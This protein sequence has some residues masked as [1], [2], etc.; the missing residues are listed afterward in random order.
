MQARERILIALDTSDAGQAV[1][2]VRLLAGHV[3][4]FKVGLELVHAAGFGIFERLREAGAERIFY[5]AK[6][7]DI[8]NTVA[9]A[10][11]AI[12]RMGVWMV[13]L[14]ASGGL[15]MMTAAAESARSVPNPPLL[16]AVTVLT[17]LSEGKL[18]E[19]LGV[20]R[21]LREQVLHLASLAREAN[22]DGVVAS[23]QE[24]ALL[25]EHIARD[26]LIVTPGIRLADEEVHDQKRVTT[27]AEAVRA[28]AD[29][30]VIGRSV[31]ADPDPLEK[32]ER[33]VRELAVLG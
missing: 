7:H 30:L 32:V 11:R 9:R 14:H 27:P 1:E 13:N 19:E 33:I 4:G 31:T 20:R 8:P 12:A 10:V 18:Q 3:G 17:S 22:L 23:A 5:D 25:R 24:A 2:W 16:I 15:E 21:G 28:G 6:L 26:F 29:Y